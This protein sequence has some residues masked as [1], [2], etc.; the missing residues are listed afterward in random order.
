MILRVRCVPINSPVVKL[1]HNH[2]ASDRR[3]PTGEALT[4]HGALA[5]AGAEA[6]EPG[7]AERRQQR[8]R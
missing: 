7:V 5:S 4:S 8:Q 3:V 1:L 6:E 2:V